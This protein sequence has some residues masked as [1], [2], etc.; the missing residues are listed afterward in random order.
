MKGLSRTFIHVS[1]LPQTPLPPRLPHNRAD[2]PA[3]HSRFLLVIHFKHSGVYLT[4]SKSLLNLQAIYRSKSSSSVLN[5]IIYLSALTR[6]KIV[7]KHIGEGSL[8][9][10]AECDTYRLQVFKVAIR[11]SSSLGLAKNSCGKYDDSHLPVLHT[12]EKSSPGKF[13]TLIL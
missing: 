13:K 10:H 6:L 5:L 12:F 8:G 1:I 4:F 9:A 2:F 11:F 7:Q 3:P